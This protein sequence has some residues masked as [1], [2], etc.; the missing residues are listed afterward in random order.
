MKSLQCSGIDSSHRDPKRFLSFVSLQ[1]CDTMSGKDK[2]VGVSLVNCRIDKSKRLN[3]LSRSGSGVRSP[4]RCLILVKIK[5]SGSLLI[6]QCKTFC[7]SAF[8]VDS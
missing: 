5:L 2:V 7:Q 8:V 6:G 3:T 1:A 4:P